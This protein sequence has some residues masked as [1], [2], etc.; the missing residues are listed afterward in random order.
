MIISDLYSE[1]SLTRDQKVNM[2]TVLI[3]DDDKEF[4]HRLKQIVET[5]LSAGRIRAKIDA[6]YSAEEIGS[7]VLASCD[8]AFLDV[9]FTG[10]QYNGLDIARR[11]RAA[12]KDAVI[13]FVTNYIE[14]APEG[15][16]VRAFR[17]ILKNDVP[18]KI[19]SSIDVIIEHIRKENSS[20]KVLSDGERIEVLLKDILYIE[21]LG[22]TLTIHLQQRP[23]RSEK[24][25][26]CHIPLAK[27]ESELSERGFLR[28]HKSFLVNMA[29]IKKLSCSEVLLDSGTTLRVSSRSYTECKRKYLLWRG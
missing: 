6:F 25:I 13:V 21:A 1:L 26:T 11:I 7:E 3:C 5:A 29:H 9:D 18:Q 19:A 20:I 4:T 16:E 12:R 22:H 24:L 14:Y 23:K 2:I 27:M 8:V 28:T 17:Y 15:Y 10:K